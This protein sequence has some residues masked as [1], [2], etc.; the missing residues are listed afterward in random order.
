MNKTVILLLSCI[1]TLSACFDSDDDIFDSNAQFQA[2]LQSIDQYLQANGIVAQVDA[3][4]GIRYVINDSGNGLQPVIADSLTI[5][6]VGKLLEDESIFETV[7]TAKRNTG[8]WLQGIL[9]A[10]SLI[11]EGGSIVAYVPSQY[12]FGNAESSGVPANSPLILEIEFHQLHAERLISELQVINDSLTNWGVNAETHPTGIRFTL[13]Q[14]TGAFPSV[15]S[16]VNVN[17]E[18]RFLGIDEPKADPGGEA[19]FTITGLIV[20]WQIM[21]PEIREGGF[22]TM[23]VPASFAYGPAGQNTIPPNANLEFDVELISI[24]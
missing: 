18:A 21:I 17:Y 20:A 19:S 4:S 8:A 5:S 13:D 22:M 16:N 7:E 1:F 15:T 11:Q 10:V 12:G 6:Y 2:D 3:V 9:S 23:Y 14:G 24:N